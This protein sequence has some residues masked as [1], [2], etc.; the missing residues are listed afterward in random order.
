MEDLEG[1]DFSVNI[2]NANTS[3]EQSLTG[4]WD[5]EWKADNEEKK[6]KPLTFIL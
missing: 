3:D 1:L 2:T 6:G 4:G 5:S